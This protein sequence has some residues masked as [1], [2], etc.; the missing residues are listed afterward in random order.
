MDD[1]TLSDALERYLRGEMT[2]EERKMSEELRKN[3]ADVDH[4]WLSINF[5]G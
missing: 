5:P 3:N 1:I 4:W 2:E